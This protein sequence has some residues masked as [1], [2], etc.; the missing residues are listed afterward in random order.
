[1]C[2]KFSLIQMLAFSCLVIS[3]GVQAQGVDLKART[4]I[5]QV[6]KG[7]VILTDID[8]PRCKKYVEKEAMYR[9]GNTLVFGCWETDFGGSSNSY[10]RVRW[11]N[12]ELS[13]FDFS[14]IQWRR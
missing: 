8:S 9:K 11:D 12:G 14:Q 10:A 7:Q 2:S 5:V 3:G 4:G 6:G 1:M 13:I